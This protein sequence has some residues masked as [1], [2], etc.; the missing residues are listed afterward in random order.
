M[1]KSIVDAH[2]TCDTDDY[3]CLTMMSNDKHGLE[4]IKELH[5][6]LDDDANGNVD[7]SETGD[8]SIRHSLT[9]VS[10]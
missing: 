1:S 2:E 7:L 10:K 6:Q 4:A 3:S 8:V 9:F 5:K